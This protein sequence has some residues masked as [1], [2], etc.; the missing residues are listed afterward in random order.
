MNLNLARLQFAVEIGINLDGPRIADAH[1]FTRR[2]LPRPDFLEQIR[3]QLARFSALPIPCGEPFIERRA[4]LA[5]DE[6]HDIPKRLVIVRTQIDAVNRGYQGL[7]PDAE[8]PL[9]HIAQDFSNEVVT[10]ETAWRAA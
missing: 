10:L 9:F 6:R 3:S 1:V 5:R 4:D 7:V 2:R 8:Q